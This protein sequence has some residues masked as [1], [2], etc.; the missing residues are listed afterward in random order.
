MEL[1]LNQ[2][3]NVYQGLFKIDSHTYNSRI[4]ITREKKLRDIFHFKKS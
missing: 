1:Q 2:F 3:I 4:Q